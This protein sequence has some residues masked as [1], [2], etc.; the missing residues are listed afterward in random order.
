M[1]SEYFEFLDR[2]TIVMLSESLSTD[3]CFP[4]ALIPSLNFFANDSLTIATF[5]PP[6]LSETVKSRPAISGTPSTW[7]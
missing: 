1:T 7:K 2:P 6:A 3:M 4:T 5:K